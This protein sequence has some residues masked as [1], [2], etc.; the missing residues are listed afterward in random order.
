LDEALGE[1][2]AGPTESM[3]T[4]RSWRTLALC[5]VLCGACSSSNEP[6]MSAPDPQP[7][8]PRC[9]DKPGMLRGKSTQTL[10]VAGVARSF[11]YY[12]HMSLDANRP[13][14]LVVVPHGYTMSGEQMF[15]ITGHDKLADREGFVVAYPNGEGAQ[16]WNVGSGVCGTGQLANATG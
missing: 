10:M 3:D 4:S 7:S 2:D 8:A 13:V 9:S 12:A 6:E 5:A 16:P 11:V 14:P 15:G 1:R